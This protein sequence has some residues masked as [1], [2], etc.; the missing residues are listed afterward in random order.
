MLPLRIACPE[1][2]LN[3]CFG[4][5]I[6]CAL[7]ETGEAQ[8]KCLQGMEKKGILLKRSEYW[9]CT[10]TIKIKGLE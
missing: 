7:F 3:L 10:G 1:Q 4:V 2:E 5:G 9:S 6:G 8:A